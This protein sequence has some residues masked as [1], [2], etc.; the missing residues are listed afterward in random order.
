[1]E[2][3]PTPDS[4]T[5]GRYWIARLESLR[6]THGALFGFVGITTLLTT[7]FLAGV[8]IDQRAITGAPAWVKPTKFGISIAV[9]SVTLLWILSLIRRDTRRRQRFVRWTGW[10]VVTTLAVELVL[11]AVQVV[12]GTSSHFNLSTS[13]DAAV[14]SIMGASIVILFLA[15]LVVA[16]VVLRER[17]E[18]RVMASAIRLGLV[19]ASI[20]MAFGFLM[21]N[22]TAQQLA[23]M[24][25]GET[26][27]F[28]GAHSV[29]VA[30][31][32]PGL[33][34]VGWSTEGG[35]LRIGHFIGMH[36]LQ[37][38][39]FLAVGLRR[40]GGSERRRRGIVRIVA[41]GYLGLTLL[42]TWQALRAQPLLRPDGVTLT[43]LG[44]LIAATAGGIAWLHLR[45]ENDD[46]EL[47][48]TTHVGST[49]AVPARQQ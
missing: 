13:F 47:E 20:G 35:D 31:G 48:T 16:V 29:G 1:M 12:R 11:I 41:A 14:F 33:P 37:V 44:L 36:A 40:S 45:T 24:D 9:Y 28:V 18:D 38:L 46:A 8:F 39:P 43:V 23:A 4:P 3:K 21:T 34:F 42:V 25:A 27:N 22:P 26:V 10:T 2:T 19:I 15:N 5:T 49:I 7:F 32:G 6:S 17:L 30:D